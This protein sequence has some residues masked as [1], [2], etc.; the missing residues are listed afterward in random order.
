MP[1][2]DFYILPQV[3]RDARHAFA[4]RLIEKAFGLGHRIYIHV[5]NEADARQIDDV[6]WSY[7]P[8]SFMPHALLA[9]R[10]DAAAPAV[11]IG[12]GNDAADHNDVLIN[13]ASNV[14]G[15][16]AG[17]ARVS[18][19]VVQEPAILAATRLSWKFYTDRGYTIQRHDMRK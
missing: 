9:Q 11:E 4:C 18:E 12:F 6:L 17:F 19:I 5:D 13:L 3:E 16:F 7:R 1:Q 8:T 10:G 2:I 15:F 14:P